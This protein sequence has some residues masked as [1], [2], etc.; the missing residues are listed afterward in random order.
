VMALCP[1]HIFQ[2]LTKRPERMQDYISD[3]FARLKVLGDGVDYE[4]RA[5]GIRWNGFW[6]DRHSQAIVGAHTWPLPNVWLG[7]SVEDQE[8]ADERI[9]LLLSTPAA[10]RFVSA[11]PLL[12]PLALNKIRRTNGDEIETTNALS[13]TWQVLDGDHY[14]GGRLASLDWVIVGGE[15]G[16]GARP[17]HPDWARS[18]RDQCASTHVPFF[19]KQWGEWVPHTVSAGGDLGGDVRAGRVMI[20]HPSGREGHE[21]MAET[22][23]RQTESGSRYMARVGKKAA[24]AMLDGVMHREFPA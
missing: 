4:L 7:V 5:A 13:G 15:S 6:N 24:G 9:P 3:P 10:K 17:L 1:Q 18:L 21:I 16:P 20:V 11:E 19:F 14:R 23:T 12:G 22:G 8:R 2:V